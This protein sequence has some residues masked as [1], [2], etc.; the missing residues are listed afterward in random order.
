MAEKFAYELQMDDGNITYYNMD[1]NPSYMNTD[2][3]QPSE[4]FADDE[5]ELELDDDML[6]ID[7]FEKALEDEDVLGGPVEDLEDFEEEEILEEPVFLME[8]DTEQMLYDG[9]KDVPEEPDDIL[10]FLDHDMGTLPGAN[11]LLV[12]E[13]E[14]TKE[15][16]WEEDGDPEKF[17]EYA[18]TKLKAIP[19]HT[20]QT[21]V[22][23]EKAMSYLRKLDK[24]ISKAIQNDESNVIDE[25]KAEKLRDKIH[26]YIDLLEDA[27]ADLNSKKRKKKKKAS[28]SLGKSV[29]ARLHDGEPK[30]FISVTSADEEERLLEVNLNVPSDEQVQAFMAGRA[31]GLTKEA[32]SLMT[33][34]DPF[35]Q[36]VTRILIQSHITQGK[37]LKDVYQRLDEQYSFTPREELSIHELLMQKGLPLNIDL[38]RLREKDVQPSDGKGISYGTEYYS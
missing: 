38:G 1:Q 33:F 27:Y 17:I 15:T 5:I 10:S 7:D 14:P 35:L 12:S 36:S 26:E 16:N 20:G 11:V 34:V 19:P 22:G 3:V 25:Q 4:M 18:V 32:G 9:P 8:E 24:E 2:I 31:K 29:V 6:S 30:Y 37:N 28:F 23:C 13:P 21:T